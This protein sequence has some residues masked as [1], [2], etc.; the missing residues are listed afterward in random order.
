MK[1]KI[2]VWTCHRVTLVSWCLRFFFSF[3]PSE[4]SIRSSSLYC[5]QICPRSSVSLSRYR[6]L[7]AFGG[8]AREAVRRSRQRPPPPRSTSS[9]MEGRP[10][11]RSGPPRW[12]RPCRRWCPCRRPGPGCTLSSSPGRRSSLEGILEAADSGGRR[13]WRWEPSGVPQYRFLGEK[14]ESFKVIRG[15]QNQEWRHK[16]Q[17]KKNTLTQFSDDLFYADLVSIHQIS[18][19]VKTLAVRLL[20]FL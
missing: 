4:T 2:W 18:N 3:D 8:R 11:R 7:V 16:E 13:R 17:N 15:N 10:P 6:P 5:P 20:C 1:T 14:Q 12:P 19:S 9:T